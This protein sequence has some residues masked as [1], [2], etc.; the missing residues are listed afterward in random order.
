MVGE[1]D[2]G[3]E[4]SADCEGEPGNRLRGGGM[5]GSLG[6]GREREDE[7]AARRPSCGRRRRRPSHCA[8]PPAGSGGGEGVVA[9]A[10]FAGQPP[11]V[12]RRHET[13]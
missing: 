8:C 11:T 5:D 12:G 9:A 1:S 2:L 13:A 10:A 3:R 7:I 6:V 4:L